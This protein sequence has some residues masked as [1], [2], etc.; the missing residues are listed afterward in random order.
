MAQEKGLAEFDAQGFVWIL[1]LYQM[2]FGRFLLGLENPRRTRK[3]CGCGS[4]PMGSHFGVG[5]FTTHF[6]TY[7]GIGMFT[8]GTGF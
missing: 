1:I 8:G 6:R 2:V 7:S 4:K 5:E 3:E